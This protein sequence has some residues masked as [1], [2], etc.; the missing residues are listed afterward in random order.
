MFIASAY[1]A[2]GMWEATSKT[3][4]TT[5]V[6]STMQ[7]TVQ[8]FV[9]LPVSIRKS[10]LE[11]RLAKA[12]GEVLPP[13]EKE[14]AVP[15][16]ADLGAVSDSVAAEWRSNI[17][18]SDPVPS[19]NTTEFESFRELSGSM[20]TENASSANYAKNELRAVSD[21]PPIADAPVLI[22]DVAKAEAAGAA[23]ARMTKLFDVGGAFA[24]KAMIGLGLAIAVTTSISLA[25]GFNNM[26]DVE[27]GL[28]IANDIITGLMPFSQ[29]A[30]LAKDAMEKAAKAVS[31]VSTRTA[32][33]AG[34]AGA[35]AGVD[36]GIDVSAEASADVAAGVS[37]EA[38]AN[39]GVVAAA[40]IGGV[41]AGE[42][43][44]ITM[45]SAAAGMCSFLAAAAGP[46][47]IAGL[48]LMFVMMTHQHEQ[49][50]PLSIFEQWVKDNAPSVIDNNPKMKDPPPPL[51]TW[52]ATQQTEANQPRTLAI[53]GK[54]TSSD[55][56]VLLERFSATFTSGTAA[57]L[58]TQFNF[59][60]E[61]EKQQITTDDQGLVGL[62]SMK[63]V[64]EADFAK[65]TADQQ[66]HASVSPMVM[67]V[68]SDP[69]PSKGTLVTW[70]VVVTAAIPVA[71][72]STTQATDSSPKQ[73]KA[74]GA[75]IKVLSGAAA[76]NPITTTQSKPTD[77]KKAAADKENA[78]AAKL[79]DDAVTPIAVPPG[80]SVCIVL[81]GNTGGPT[82][83][84]S[85]IGDTDGIA[86]NIHE[87]WI[88]NGRPWDGID[89]IQHIRKV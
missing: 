76:A 15:S 43:A 29:I 75:S 8:L 51:L 19:A 39:M 18:Q 85:E 25:Q 50:P 33:N 32:Q 46:L 28:G 21:A 81:K 37:G 49:D 58:F 20:P 89:L 47:A 60:K 79:K 84:N 41:A 83:T 71:T 42:A 62:R 16:E 9:D 1:S 36:V 70:A 5:L 87:G 30:S 4:R 12:K 24:E 80:A 61:S 74:A 54:N 26:D 78:D 59:D 55:A 64:S 10:V 13:G 57:A 17:A 53:T 65:M 7:A 48:V 6:L 82:P 52:T 11:Y 77:S 40:D 67:G 14:M 3:D 27:K 66:A 86:V 56:S 63:S 2:Y 69:T 31:D 22:S 73:S 34:Q 45:A 88:K 38:A 72:T 44:G 35:E 68:A 23:E